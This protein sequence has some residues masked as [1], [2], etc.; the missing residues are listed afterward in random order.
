[1]N[2]PSSWR[3]LSLKFLGA[4]RRFRSSFL[5]LPGW[6]K[7]GVVF[8]TALLLFNGLG[9]LSYFSYR[10]QLESEQRVAQAKQLLATD[11][12]NAGQIQGTRDLDFWTHRSSDASRLHAASLVLGN[13]LAIILISLG[14]HSLMFH[15]SLGE[16]STKALREIQLYVDA[17]AEAVYG[18]DLDGNCVF[19]NRALLRLLG[20][21]SANE[22]ID[23]KI[24]GLIFAPG[25]GSSESV[26]GGRIMHSLAEMRPFHAD[27]G[28]ALRA[29]G[30]SLRVEYWSN[31]VHEEGHL[32]GAA[33]TLQDV[34]VSRA[35]KERLEKAYEG[36]KVEV[37]ELSRHSEEMSAFS[38]LTEMLQSSTSAEELCRV[39][40]VFA[41]QLFPQESGVLYLYREQNKLHEPAAMWGEQLQAP[42]PFLQDECWSLRRSKP[43]Y[44]ERDKEGLFCA[45]LVGT[46]PGY[47]LCLPLIAQGGT[48]GMM[49]LAPSRGS[50]VTRLNEPKQLLA[51]ALAQQVALGLSN[52]KLRDFLREDAIR[53]A[54][55]GL[56][57][58]RYMKESLD[59]EVSRALRSGSTVGLITFDLDHFKEVNDSKGHA[60]GDRL[61]QALGAVVKDSVRAGDIP[62]RYGGDEFLVILPGISAAQAVDLA[63][64]L[65]EKVERLMPELTDK[66]RKPCTLSAGVAMFPADAQTAEGLQLAADRAL[67]KAKDGGRNRVA[68]ARYLGPDMLQASEHRP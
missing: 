63:E 26:E 6:L 55:T 37:Q 53:D 65:R 44:E 68:S 51:T 12:S 62:C 10:W 19:C 17:S 21:I 45:H 16:S 23:K 57:N 42:Q 64:K 4:A 13:L 67:Y 34:S 2:S 15:M 35:A 59:H 52:L 39:V 38:A 43:H 11:H 25:P 47:S 33:V 40:T 36:L 50:D 29:D 31:P 27:D 18:I 24:H 58:R 60:T 49:H 9:A 56:Y 7:G 32:Q 1:M 46:H 3:A 28:R 66:D 5:R 8:G 41:R 30:S 20:Y 22:L 54:L 61:L 48:L 14:A